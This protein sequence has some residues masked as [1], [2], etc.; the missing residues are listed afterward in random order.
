M[1]LIV[2]PTIVHAG[3]WSAIDSGYAVESNYHGIE[4]IIPPPPT[5]LRAR[6]GCLTENFYD[7]ISGAGVYEVVVHLR[8]PDGDV[9]DS[10]TVSWTDMVPGTSPHG[11]PIM[12]QWTSVDHY[13]APATWEV[14]DYSIKAYFYDE[15]GKELKNED[16]LTAMRATTVMVVP[17]VPI[18]TLIIM[19][20]MLAGLAILARKRF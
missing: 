19:L 2:T 14:G 3:P 11:A 12:W 13:F 20:T 5:D 9:V 16:D 10:A 7:P 17:E 15:H 18:G 8:D 1:T 4:I 6:V